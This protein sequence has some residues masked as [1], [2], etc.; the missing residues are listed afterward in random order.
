VK[1]PH[2]A[3]IGE[4]GFVCGIWLLFWVH[5]VFGRWPFRLCL[6]P[7]VFLHWYG[8]PALR[9]ASR[10]YLR[11]LE[12]ATGAL[13]HPPGIRDGLRHVGLF[14]E[15]M[16]DKLLAVSGSYPFA[17]VKVEGRELIREAQPDGRGAVIVTAH[18]GCL[19]LCRVLGENKAGI[20]L[21]VLVHTRHAEQ[22]NRVLRRLNPDNDLNLMEVSEVGPATAVL[23]AEKVEAGEYV[24]IAGDRVPVFA[25]QTVAVDFLGEPAPF[26]VGPYVL[27]SLLKC[28]LLALGCV[29]EGL[30]Y[31]L[32]FSLLA[33]RVV[34]PR[35]RRAA[36]MAEY[37]AAYAAELTAM[38]V[39][40][41][42]DWFNFF[43][44]WDQA[45]AK[46][47]N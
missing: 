33:D 45:H 38:L 29:H 3:E 44:F 30:G 16:L 8:K 25:S 14:A 26:P 27:A 23:L 42:Y 35:G 18:T 36:A 37:A 32:R 31:R 28:R 17:Q 12:G 43:P 22:F 6:Y 20:K 40:S 46:P 13:G 10:Q 24:A 9:R 1:Q 39:R 2:W 7:I 47:A 11:R 41:P 4:S 19:E 15:T 5:R 34:L 21:N